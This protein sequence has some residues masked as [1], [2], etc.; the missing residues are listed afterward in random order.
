L[1]FAS[2]DDQFDERKPSRI[3]RCRFFQFAQRLRAKAAT[4]LTWLVRRLASTRAFRCS[5]GRALAVGGWVIRVRILEF[6]AV[7]VVI[8]FVRVRVTVFEPIVVLVETN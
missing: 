7:D 3:R 6:I 2:T 8:E 5:G 1:S 4:R